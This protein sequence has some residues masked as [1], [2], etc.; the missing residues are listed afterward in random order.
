MSAYVHDLQLA[1]VIE[2]WHLARMYN[3]RL[4]LLLVQIPHVL[5]GVLAF[6]VVARSRD[7]VLQRHPFVPQFLQNSYWPKNSW[8]SKNKT[9]NIHNKYSRSMLICIGTICIYVHDLTQR[10]T[11]K[12]NTIQN[13]IQYN[14][15][16]SIMLQYPGSECMCCLVIVLINTSFLACNAFSKWSW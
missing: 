13:T 2:C 12:Q 8:K 3:P 16:S 4:A 1:S 7:W 5:I 6:S 14:K 11:I 15:I 9:C 10:N